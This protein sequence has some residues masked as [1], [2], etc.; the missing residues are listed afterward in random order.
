FLAYQT[1]EEVQ[2]SWCSR[3]G[4]IPVRPAV[5]KQVD[6]SQKPELKVFFEQ[7]LTAKARPP[8]PSYDKLEEIA[9]AQMDLALQGLK[10]PKDA[11]SDAAARINAD[12]LQPLRE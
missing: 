6:T 3:L 2:R 1:S 5:F 10:S 12:V 4:Q 11:L 9:N 7:M 8:V